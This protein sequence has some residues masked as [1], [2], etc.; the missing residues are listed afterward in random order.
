MHFSAKSASFIKPFVEKSKSLP[1]HPQNLKKPN[2]SA[3]L[4]VQMPFT[5]VLFRLSHIGRAKP[6]F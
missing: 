5:Y 3:G 1:A 6:L 2:D 4:Q